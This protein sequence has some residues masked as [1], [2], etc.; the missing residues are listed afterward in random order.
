MSTAGI[1]PWIMQRIEP[2]KNI[3]AIFHA[4]I[5]WEKYPFSTSAKWPIL[6]A[7]RQLLLI[8]PVVVPT[9]PQR[10]IFPL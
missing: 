1:N 9:G 6:E 10:R 5:R 7:A 3:A 2:M 8:W 4:P